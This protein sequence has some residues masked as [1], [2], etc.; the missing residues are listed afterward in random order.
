MKSFCEKGNDLRFSV[1][2]DVFRISL[3]YQIRNYKM[4]NEHSASYNKYCSAYTG[5]I[6]LIL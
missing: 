6:R 2:G 1:K 5:I 3:P 4:C